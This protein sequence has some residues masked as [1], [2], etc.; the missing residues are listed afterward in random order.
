MALSSFVYRLPPEGYGL[1]SGSSP[2]QQHGDEEE[3]S[4]EGSQISDHSVSVEQAMRTRQFY[5]MYFGMLSAASKS[6]QSL[7]RSLPFL[8]PLGK[9]LST[10]RPRQSPNSHHLT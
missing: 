6:L 7:F 2:K 10:S 5:L 3:A 4:K 1:D 9:L 8:F